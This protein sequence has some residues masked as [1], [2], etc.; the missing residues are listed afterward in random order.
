VLGLSPD[1]WT[2]IGSL[3]AVGTLLLSGWSIYRHERRRSPATA[4]APRISP[5]PERTSSPAPT[6]TDYDPT[7]PFAPDGILSGMEV[8]KFADHQVREPMPPP[9]GEIIGR[10]S[11]CPCGSGRKY[12]KCHGA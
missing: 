4:P 7:A 10:N 8:L 3:A 12:K 11:P 9:E 1:E 5:A 6:T 2:A